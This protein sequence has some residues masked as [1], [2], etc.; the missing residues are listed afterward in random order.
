MVAIFCGN[1]IRKI[2]CPF[3][4]LKEVSQE[5]YVYLDMLEHFTLTRHSNVHIP[6]DDAPRHL[7]MNVRDSLEKISPERWIGRDGPIGWPASS[8]DLTLC[9]S[10]M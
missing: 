3:S 4:L 5:L 1:M 2:L 7:S 10:F 6:V 8:P 9:D